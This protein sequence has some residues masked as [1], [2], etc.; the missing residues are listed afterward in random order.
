MNKFFKLE[1]RGTTIKMEVMAGIITFLSMA[2][3]I[4]VNPDMLS[5]TGMDQGAVFTATILASVIGTLIMG[6]FANFPVALA[7][8]MGMNAF[9]TFTVVLTYGYSWQQALAGI[10]VSGI[11]F[12]ILSVTGLREL[13]INSIPKSLK[14]AVGV[15]IG[16]FIAFIGLVN[17]G[18]VV[19]NEATLVGLGN[20]TDPNV[21]LAVFGVIVMLFL[22]VRKVPAAIFIGMVATVIIGL[23]TGLIAMPTQVV[24][25]VP[26]LE[27]TFGALFEALPSIFSFD[28]V[29]IIFSF[30]FVDF[31]D[32]AGT[33]I[34]VGTNAGLINK[35]GELIDADKALLSDSTATVIGSV[36]GTS[37]T[38]SF[39]ESLAGVG[40]G[41][42]TGLTAVVTAICFLVMLFFSPL[43]GIITSA[44]TAPALIAVGMLM[45]SSLGHIEWDEIETTIP[46]FATIIVMLLG[47]S[48]AEGIAVGFTLYPIMMIAARRTKEIKPVMWV[49]MAIFL[50]HFMMPVF[51]K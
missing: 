46:A 40:A 10:F 47:Y 36:L 14:H 9:F 7:P 2:Y 11:I 44:V 50:C 33:L 34:S 24:S 38:T 45:A 18:I 5:A 51:M 30:L 15:G 49:L 20:F 32:T 35:D 28:M 12:M 19:N 4:F 3:I 39:V 21:L 13:I 1:E 22:L 8:G 27:P 37:S 48:I 23:F 41:G 25:A 29:P 31:F 43:L 6:L 26:S 17:A 16:F 42:R